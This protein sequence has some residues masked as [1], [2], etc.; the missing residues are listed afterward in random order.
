MR[1]IF[2]RRLLRGLQRIARSLG[3]D[4]T[5]VDVLCKLARELLTEVMPPKPKAKKK[6]KKKAAKKKSAKKKRSRK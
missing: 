5:D 1:G 4:C 2:A 6:A 3:R